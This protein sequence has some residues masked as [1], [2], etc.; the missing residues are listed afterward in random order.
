MTNMAPVAREPDVPVEVHHFDIGGIPLDIADEH[1]SCAA[2]IVADE[3]AGDEYALNEL[4]LEPGDCIVDIG[5][6][7]G[8]FSI[9]LAKRFPG[10]S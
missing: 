7:V 5:G 1:G 8:L 6:H 4:R 9:F 10:M 3:L 2:R